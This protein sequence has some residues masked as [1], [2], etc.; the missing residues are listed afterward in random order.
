MPVPEK[1]FAEALERY[2]GAKRL[3]V[4]RGKACHDTAVIRRAES[5]APSASVLGG[6]HCERVVRHPPNRHRFRIGIRKG[7]LRPR[8]ERIRT[9]RR[10]DRTEIYREASGM[11]Q[12]PRR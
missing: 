4:G 7:G 8:K 5:F 6:Q 3:R 10:M 11:C 12:R 1:T 9:A 2:I